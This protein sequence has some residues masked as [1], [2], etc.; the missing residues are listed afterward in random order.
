MNTVPGKM[1]P[2]KVISGIILA[3]MTAF[4]VFPQY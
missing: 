1:T 3:I 2:Y 4:L